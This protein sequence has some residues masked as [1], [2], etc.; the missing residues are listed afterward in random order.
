MRSPEPGGLCPT[1]PQAER[2][3]C[4]KLQVFGVPWTAIRARVPSFYQADVTGRAASPIAETKDLRGSGWGMGRGLLASTADGRGELQR[5]VGL[6]TSMVGGWGATPV[7]YGK[8]TGRPSPSPIRILFVKFF[9][10]Y[11]IQ[12]SI[13]SVRFNFNPCIH[14]ATTIQIKM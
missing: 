11:N 10:R 9:L 6:G 8:A 12:Q 13:S 2:P 4:R 7:H 1:S 3:P 14:C 5:L